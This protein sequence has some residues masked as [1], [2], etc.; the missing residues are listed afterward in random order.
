[1]EH[2][3]LTD[4]RPGISNR[5]RCVYIAVTLVACTVLGLVAA[6]WFLRSFGQRWLPHFGY[7][8]LRP[9]QSRTPFF[10]PDPVLGWRVKS[11]QFIVPAYSGN[12]PGIRMTFL[13]GGRRVTELGSP[14]PGRE[15]VAL[16]G[17]SYTQGWAISDDETFPWRL[18]QAHPRTGVSELWSRRTGRTS[19]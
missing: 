17:G 15:V 1:M 11:G 14:L 16:V 4:Q 8:A 5:K 6:E 12:G 2:L 3:R 13:S 10:E 9:R 18:Q 7:E 19:R